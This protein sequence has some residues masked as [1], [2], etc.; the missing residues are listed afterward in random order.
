VRVLSGLV[1]TREEIR[2]REIRETKKDGSAVD[3]SLYAAPI[4]DADGGVS[5]VLGVFE[6]ISRR[7]REEEELAR[8]E[9][10]YRLLAENAVDV[11]WTTDFDLHF[12]FVSKS[13]ETLLGYRPD[14]LIGSGVEKHLTPESRRIVFE[15][16]S[17]TF[18][19][20]KRGDLELPI[21]SLVFE[22]EQVR[23]DGS[24]VWTEVKVNFQLDAKNRPQGIVGVSRDIS[25]RKQ[26][27]SEKEK[28]RN[29]LFQAQK[30][31]AVGI[32]AGGVA[33]DFNNLLTAIQGN[34]DLAEMKSGSENTVVA[35]HLKQ[36]RNS[37]V[38]AS[39]MTRKLLLFSRRQPSR[40]RL[41]N[42]NKV[43]QGM[44]KILT[45]LI[46]EDVEIRTRIEESIA[47]I[48]ADPAN[49]EQ[50]LMNLCLNSRDAMPEGG[51]LE[52]TTENVPRD[53]IPFVDDALEASDYVHIAIRDT[54]GGMEKEEIEHIFEPFYTTKDMGRGSGLGLAVVYGIVQQNKASIHV[55]SVPGEGTTFHVYFPALNLSDDE[56]EPDPVTLE[57]FRGQGETLLL[58]EDAKT[59][60]LYLEEVLTR[61]GYRVLS[62]ADA[63]GALEVFRDF[64]DEIRLVFSDVV[65]PDQTGIRLVETILSEKPRIPVVYT[66]GYLGDRS[67]GEEIEK[68]NIPFL[69]KPFTLYQVLKIIHRQFHPIDS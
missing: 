35:P 26:A 39:S 7:K 8:K 50:M 47:S 62:A 25:R 38:M 18:S 66:S 43:V 11:I 31:E 36:I 33:H 37:V 69:Q 64:R 55:E 22:L 12:T 68:K 51:L 3:I 27:E 63:A 14:E 57:R 46:G 58:V 34:V 15:M 21:P 32:L 10:R 16:H 49:I 54:G 48:R 24:T 52:V 56:V 9:E 6:D 29:Q 23:R 53:A 65:L 2:D 5:G 28:I 17:R 40:P 44:L 45:R 61:Y 13:V 41:V 1:A 4:I 30:L 42:V 59:V 20:W 67:H 19:R 60:R